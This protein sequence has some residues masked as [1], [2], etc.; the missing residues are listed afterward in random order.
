[1]PRRNVTRKR[2][3]HFYNGSA[4]S[5]GKRFLSKLNKGGKAVTLT[6]LETILKEAL[7]VYISRG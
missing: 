1:M 4:N 6:R 3:N 5:R 2:Y 7:N